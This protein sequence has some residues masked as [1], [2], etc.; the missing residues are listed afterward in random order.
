MEPETPRPESTLLRCAAVL[1]AAVI[2]VLALGTALAG[3]FY[4]SAW[5]PAALGVA[6]ALVVAASSGR[7]RALG[8]VQRLAATAA[9]LFAAFSYLSILWAGLPGTSLTEANRSAT[10][11]GG[12]LAVLLVAD[13]ARRRAD[14]LAVFAGASGLFALTAAASSAIGAHLAQFTGGRLYGAIGYPNAVSLFSVACLCP[15][16]TYAA[17]RDLPV[18]VR[19]VAM[20]FAGLVPGVVLLT[21]SRAGAYFTILGILVFLVASPLRVRS[22]VALSLALTPLAL[23]W[24]TIRRPGLVGNGNGVVTAAETQAAGRAVLLVALGAA[25]LGAAWALLDRRVAIADRGRLL[26]RRGLL[27]V[28]VASL[29]GGVVLAVSR[30]VVG[31]ART[32]WTAF[33]EGQAA[34]VND[35][36]SDRYLSVGTNRYDFWRVAVVDLKDRPLQGYGAGNWSWTYLSAGRSDEEPDNAHGAVWEFAA[37]LGITGLVL[38][39]LVLVTAFVAA[40]RPAPGRDRRESAALLGTLA[41]TVGHQQ[42][43]WMWE[44]FSCGLLIAG[45]LGLALAG[46]RRPEGRPFSPVARRAVLVGAIGVALVGI[47]PALVAERFG[48]QSY[49]LDPASALADARRAAALAPLSSAVEFARADAALRSGRASEALAAMR[50]AVAR[51]PKAWAAWARL[52]GLEAS[53]G[54]VRASTAACARARDINPKADC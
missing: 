46:A 41:M 21:V 2:P 54:G 5:Y 28:V 24:D 34:T 29:L 45:L 42:V 35:A 49:Y 31:T 47:V 27:A 3:G 40:A 19:S 12:L 17:R 15:L 11:A 43:D 25:A 26:L 23:G 53:A 33:T 51:E 14:L 10:Y 38:Y 4:G 1:P 18:L 22:G 52:A 50:E 20:G 48:D 9:V 32:K 30:D 16:L 39:L 8:T 44:T 13:S 6:L 7:L 37:D 36:T